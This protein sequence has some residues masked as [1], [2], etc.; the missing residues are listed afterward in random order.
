MLGE[1]ILMSAGLSSWAR[2]SFYPKYPPDSTALREKA[3]GARGCRGPE[4]CSPFPSPREARISDLGSDL[5]RV[6]FRER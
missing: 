5:L 2:D 3:P 6:T 1:N 4:S